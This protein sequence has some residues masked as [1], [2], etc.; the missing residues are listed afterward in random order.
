ML[1]KK[2]AP[3]FKAEVVQR[4]AHRGDT[5]VPQLCDEFKLG[6]SQIYQWVK[7]AAK[8]AAEKEESMPAQQDTAEDSA[9]TAA[10]KVRR[11]PKAK[12]KQVVVREVFSETQTAIMTSCEEIKA[13]LL[14]KNRRYGD[15]A[16]GPVGVFSNSTPLDQIAARCDDKLSR[17]RAQGGLTR[18]LTDNSTDG[19]DTTLDLI[20]YLIL[21]RIVAAG[22][23]TR[24][25]TETHASP[26]ARLKAVG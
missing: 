26:R 13:L 6:P 15:S 7:D 9:E 4:F 14:D 3:E 16:R 23:R 20:G 2:H 18:V 10:P 21:G 11:K 24:G 17:I 1:R 8:A 25:E 22:E 12:K 5:T 19:E